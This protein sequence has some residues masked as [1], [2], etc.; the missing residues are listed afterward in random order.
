MSGKKI[1]TMA[2]RKIREA[3]GEAHVFAE[4]ANGRTLKDIAEG[5]GI[6]RPIL[7][8]W[9][10]HPSR[11]DALAHARRA[12]ASALA[13][14]GL[15]LV[16]AVSDPA[17]VPAAKLQ[18]DYRRWMA[19]RLSSEDWGEQRGALVNIQVSDLHLE[20]LRRIRVIEGEGD[21]DADGA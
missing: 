2:H 17:D 11:K 15:A 9:A 7:S 6:T 1:T 12:A 3:G 14:Q 8:A 19:S 16:D 13:E 4:V 21:A 18:S 5:L 10:N 20:S